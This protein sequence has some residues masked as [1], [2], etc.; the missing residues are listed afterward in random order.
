M[1]VSPEI[2]PENQSA[3]SSMPNSDDQAEGMDGFMI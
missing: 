3:G 1:R 2:I